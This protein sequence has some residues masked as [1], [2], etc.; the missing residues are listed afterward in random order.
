MTNSRHPSLDLGVSRRRALALGAAAAASTLLPRALLA[1]SATSELVA[2]R[3]IPSTGEPLP[4]I[5]LGTAIIFDI[6]EATGVRAERAEVIRTLVEGGGSLIDTAPSY[7]RAE[8]VL[9]DLLTETKLRPK[10][11]LATKVAVGDRDAQLEEMRASLKKLQVE[12]VDLLQL[13]NVRDPKQ[14]LAVLREWKDKGLCRYIGITSSFD[15]DYPAVEAVLTRE[16]PDFFQIDYSLANRNAEERLLPAAQEVGAAVLTN[17]PF[18]RGALFNAVHGQTLPDWA[19]EI[20]AAS[21]A[22]IFLKFLLGNPAVT[23]VIPGT[24]KR[25]Y[26]LDN[27]GAGRGRLPDAAMRRRMIDWYESAKG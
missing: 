24:D 7:G 19:A 4:V 21:W 10:I 3:P 16:K 26:M 13:H 5:G 25:D 22:Q 14:D 15:R 6:G 17:L 12:K 9:G 18:G 2:T 8:S 11:F 20:D 23:A 27:L 1:Q